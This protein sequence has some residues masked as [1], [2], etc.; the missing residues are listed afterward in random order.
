[1]NL[2][3][4][5]SQMPPQGGRVPEGRAEGPSVRNRGELNSAEHHRDH[6]GDADL[7]ERVLQNANVSTALKRVEANRGSAGID[8]MTTQELRPY[9]RENWQRIRQE[10]RDG[11]YRPSPV[12]WCGIPKA[13]GGEREL[14]IPTVLDRFLQQ[15]LLQVLQPEYDRTFSDHSFGF[16]PNRRAHDAVARAQRYVEEGRRIVVDVDLEK[17]FDR[18][19]H[20]ILMNRLARRI[21][22]VRVLGLI[23][24]FLN[25]GVLK[26]GVVMERE[27][28]TPQGGPLSPLLANVLLDEVDKELE[29]RG[30]AFVRYADDLNVYVRT[31]RAGERMLDSLR[32]LYS[33]LKLRINESKSAVALAW[34]R[35]FLGFSFWW[36]PGK[37]LR[38]RVAKPALDKLKA[39]VRQITD[40]NGGRSIEQVVRELK[41]YLTG[42]S[43]YFGRAETRQAFHDLD[44]WIRHRLRALHLQQWK[45][46]TT[47]FRELRA[48]GA[49]EQ[50]AAEIARGARRYWWNASKRLHHV[51]T[52]AYFA[53]LGVP[54]LAK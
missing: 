28:G 51:L 40:R 53:K 32:K 10:L 4:R 52:N 7:M 45:R 33:N 31:R 22:D 47:T 1:M 41:S 19:N 23:R 2:E 50:L 6:L 20:D 30:H 54:T 48:R 24:A 5:E 9:L 12:K 17:F 21:R 37:H 29:R 3:G 27:D 42:W 44:G 8:G 25:A 46:G 35:K 49:S 11:T 39:R 16:R 26:N 13:G 14:G 18:V 36:A 15:S 34:E 43:G 38:W